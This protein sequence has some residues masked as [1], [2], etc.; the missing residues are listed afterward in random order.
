M[1]TRLEVCRFC[2]L[3]K[4][5]HRIREI[6]GRNGYVRQL[7]CVDGQP[8]ELM[9]FPRAAADV[10]VRFI[11]MP[12]V[13][14]SEKGEEDM[15]T[16]VQRL[17]AFDSNRADVHDMVDLLSSALGVRQAYYE[18]GVP[19][20]EGLM[21]GIDTLKAQI[22]THKRDAI[23]KRLK[24]IKAQKTTLLSV[25]EKRAALESEEAALLESLAPKEPTPA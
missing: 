23:Q 22:D 24:E 5:N 7:V 17:A 16:V 3:Q 9:Q 13:T 11:P 21:S 8:F 12:T 15:L 20:P 6:A 19:V 25:T 14:Q 4:D 1:T 18:T 10:M 2:G